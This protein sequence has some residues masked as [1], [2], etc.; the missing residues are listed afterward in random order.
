MI[1]AGMI[2]G[3]AP[4]VRNARGEVAKLLSLY[5]AGFYLVAIR[6]YVAASCIAPDSDP[7]RSDQG[8]LRSDVGTCCPV[9]S[10]AWAIEKGPTT[11]RRSRFRANLGQRE[12]VIS[13]SNLK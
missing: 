8:A 2:S 4:A 13:A 5:P 10:L 6:P 3:A 7:R 12:S 1:Y 9:R 11:A